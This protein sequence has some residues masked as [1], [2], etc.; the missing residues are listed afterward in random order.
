M[1]CSV[2]LA[3]PNGEARV[4]VV[5]GSLAYIQK[6]GVKAWWQ[7]I[8]RGSLRHTADVVASQLQAGVGAMTDGG[9]RSNRAVR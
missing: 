2:T 5:R 1:T 3:E 7:V 6:G 8:P 4:R 9:V